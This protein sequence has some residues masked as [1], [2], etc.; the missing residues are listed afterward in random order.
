LVAEKGVGTLLD[1]AGL[2]KARQCRFRI[3]II[4]DGPEREPLQRMVSRASLDDVV[5]FEG[6]LTGSELQEMLTEVS[7]VVVPSIWEEPAPLS[8]LEQIMQ[9]RLVI[10][11]NIGG[12]AEQIGDAG[13][14]FEVGNSAALADQMQ[15]V[16]EDPL[17]ITQL[18]DRSRERAL[19]LYSLDRMLQEYRILIQGE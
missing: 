6:F 2:L 7:V 5:S 17:S 19:K 1:A 15:R 14:R 13:L 4:G 18:I 9:N 3:L 8:P 11:S 16:I 10:G 12:L